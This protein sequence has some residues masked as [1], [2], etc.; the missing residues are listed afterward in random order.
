L[1][2]FGQKSKAREVVLILDCCHAGGALTA[3]GSNELRQDAAEFI[4]TAG[5][6]VLAG[7]RGDQKGWEVKDANAQRLGAFSFHIL[8]GLL[9]NGVLP[10][11]NHVTASS[12]GNYVIDSFQAW[13]QTPI[14]LNQE[15]GE[16]RCIITSNLAI[17]SPAARTEKKVAELLRTNLPFK[18]STTFV[19]RSA[20]LEYLKALLLDGSRPIAVSATIEGLGGIGKTELVLQLLFDPEISRSF[21]SIVWLDAAGPLAPQ[22]ADT[23]KRLGCKKVPREAADILSL[24]SEKLNARGRSLIVLDNATDWKSVHSYIPEGMPLLVTTRASDFGGT[25]F[26]HRELGTLSDEAAR[27]LLTKLVPTLVT[28]PALPHL[29]EALGG[30]ALAI[31]LAGYHIKD[32]CSATEYLERLRRNQADF[33]SDV[34]GKTHYQ[35]TVDACLEITWDGLT[36][37]AARLLWKK[38]SLFAPT[39]AHRD[40]L[41]I[42]FA[43]DLKGYGRDVEYLLYELGYESESI[44]EREVFLLGSDSEFDSAYAEL[45]GCHVLARVEGFNG[46]RWAMHRLV[47]DFARK[48]LGKREIPVHTMLLA[49]W[50]RKPSLPLTPEVPHFV[51]AILDFAREGRLFSQSARFERGITH[52]LGSELFAT[53]D[54]TRYFSD[55]LNDPRAVVLMFEGL[56]D[57]NEDVR[58]A[59]IRLMEQVGPVPEVLDGL[60]SALDDPD[61][62]VREI[63]S[64]SL[65]QHGGTRTIEVLEAAIENAN[66]RAQLAATN[67]LALMGRKALPA[68]RRVATGTDE[69]LKL[70]ASILLAKEADGIGAKTILA[71]IQANPKQDLVRR[72]QALEYLMMNSRADVDLVRGLASL[73]ID[74][75][76]SVRDLIIRT[77]GNIKDSKT[78]KVMEELIA[79]QDDDGKAAAVQVLGLIGQKAHALLRKVSDSEDPKL[80]VEAATLLAEQKDGSRSGVVLGSI[81]PS[82]DEDVLIRRIRAIRSLDSANTNEALATLLIEILPGISANPKSERKLHAALNLA[83]LGH[84]VG[85][86]YLSSWLSKNYS[87]NAEHTRRVLSAV[88]QLSSPADSVSHIVLGLRSWSLRTDA[89]KLLGLLTGEEVVPELIKAL[90]DKDPNVRKEVTMTLGRMRASSTHSIVAKLA[91]NDSDREVR[92]AAN[93]A[94]KAFEMS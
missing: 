60:V 25:D 3:V 70:E 24:V 94:L 14:S 67:A 37:D 33:S 44:R 49:N 52:R 90:S 78:V 51:A 2:L 72:V 73:I 69:V 87:S 6:A 55:E 47:R 4:R 1:T 11:R 81:D 28:D 36:R 12:L 50:L 45:R 64:T 38:A 20:E 17:Q 91:Q 57:I 62:H 74:S 82:L 30:H 31:E 86:K 27:G 22:W 93:F 23:A 79:L 63:A 48:R 92:R 68:L 77:L 43:G 7:C 34:V 8:E 16:R 58:I 71:A 76:G 61:P 26:L 40:L 32:L 80:S 75:S 54:M 66:P 13:N 39:S 56:R 65:T 15:T 83:E 18:P 46:E 21:A 9:G 85:L 88:V 10:G 53:A 35:A 84:D 41:R 42:A 59:S 19:G 29:I 5:R 89:A